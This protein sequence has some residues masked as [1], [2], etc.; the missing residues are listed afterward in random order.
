MNLNDKVFKQF[1]PNFY[2]E[3]YHMWG[4]HVSD[5]IFFCSFLVR[6]QR[7]WNPSTGRCRISFTHHN[8]IK[9][10][11]SY[12]SGPTV[13]IQGGEYCNGNMLVRAECV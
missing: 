10:L 12:K 11:S 6:K 5:T 13:Q 9:L 7:N 3:K 2:R 8:F 1:K 4:T